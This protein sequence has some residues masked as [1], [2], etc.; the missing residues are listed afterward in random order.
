VVRVEKFQFITRKNAFIIKNDFFVIE[1]YK[2]HMIQIDNEYID[3]KRHKCVLIL[4]NS[5][6]SE[7]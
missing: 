1:N 5:I 2:I 6:L 3:I 4:K 7:F